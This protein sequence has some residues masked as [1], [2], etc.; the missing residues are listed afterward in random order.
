M[1]GRLRWPWGLEGSQSGFQPEIS[2]RILLSGFPFSGN[3]CFRMLFWEDRQSTWHRAFCILSSL[4]S[5]LCWPKTYRLPV[6]SPVK[7]GLFS[8]SKE[9]QFRICN[10]ASHMHSKGRKMLFREENQGGRA[11]V[12]KE[13]RAFHWRSPCQESR[14]IFLLLGCALTAGVWELLTSQLYLI[15]VFCLL[16]FYTFNR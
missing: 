9:L 7:I 11:L 3:R 10:C 15:K 6:I 16:I 14:G 13:S 5:L 8:I 1:W 4:I 12:N 2:D